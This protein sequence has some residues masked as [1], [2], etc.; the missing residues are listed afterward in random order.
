[1]LQEAPQLPVH[2]L[3]SVQSKEQLA[4]AQPL[5]AMSHAAPPGQLQLEP[6]QDSG[7][8]P[9]DPLPQAVKHA[10]RARIKNILGLREEV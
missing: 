3:L 8:R 6:L 9:E 5:P 4:L 1:M 7:C 10:K 2:S